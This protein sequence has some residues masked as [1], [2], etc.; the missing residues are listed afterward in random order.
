[1]RDNSGKM[2]NITKKS[3][4]QKAAGTVSSQ[5]YENSR[6]AKIRNPANFH[7]VTKIG[8][9]AKLSGALLLLPV[10]ILLPVSDL[11]L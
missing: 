1:M 2:K 9:P 7:R 6:V 8:N 4:R 10:V 5:P 11:Q 3:K